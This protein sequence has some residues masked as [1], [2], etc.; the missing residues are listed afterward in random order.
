MF[1]LRKFTFVAVPLLCVMLLKTDGLA[2]QN[3]DD[4]AVLYLQRGQRSLALEQYHLLQSIDY[5]MSQKLFGI[6]FRDKILNVRD[7]GRE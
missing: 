5:E 7:Q 2:A 1:R 6:I 3:R 4:L